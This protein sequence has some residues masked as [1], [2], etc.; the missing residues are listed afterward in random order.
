MSAKLLKYELSHSYSSII[1]EPRF[2]AWPVNVY[3]MALPIQKKM[4]S[5]LNCFETFVLK[6]LRAVKWTTL[7]AFA[8]ET[9]LD[10]STLSEI[11]RKLKD[12]EYIDD[13]HNVVF[14]KMEELDSVE[15]DYKTAFIFQDAISGSFLPY[16]QYG[17]LV[18]DTET[19]EDEYLEIQRTQNQNP[20][21]TPQTDDVWRA[22]RRM[23]KK[24]AFYDQ[25][26]PISVRAE[27]KIKIMPKSEQ[28]HLLCPIV[29]PKGGL[30]DFRIY[31][32]FGVG[33]ESDLENSFKL[34]LAKDESFVQ[35]WFARWKQTLKAKESSATTKKKFAFDACKDRYPELV[36]QLRPDVG[37]QFRSAS[38]IYASIEWALYYYAQKFDWNSAIDNLENLVF[39]K[40]LEQKLEFILSRFGI[41]PV[42]LITSLY[43]ERV[44]K[45]KSGIVEMGAIW[46][47]AL[48]QLDSNRGNAEN[49]LTLL[50]EHPDIFMR[51][52]KL[53]S[54]RGADR[55]GRNEGAIADVEL[56]DDKLMREI[57][58][59][60]LPDVDFE[61]AQQTVSASIDAEDAIFNARIS[62]QQ[63][64][65][66]ISVFNK[67]RPAL[68]RYLIDAERID[69][70]ISLQHSDE[71]DC[72]GFIGALY[73]A[74][75][76]V[77]DEKLEDSI[78]SEGNKESA[79][80]NAV[81]AGFATI[82]DAILSVKRD[83]VALGTTLGA[84]VL[85]YLATADIEDLKVC[86][87]N[88]PEM[89]D[90]ISEVIV[91]S[92]HGNAKLTM[93]P[94]KREELKQKVYIL[95]KELLR[96]D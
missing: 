51:I 33:F 88:N 9:C 10:V 4:S 13:N 16:I 93:S 31:S 32:P 81:Q 49:M 29:V 42:R 35:S 72:S 54:Y 53:S 70:N 74:L 76:S 36:N 60:L 91:L 22:I 79:K 58:H 67:M 26:C 89:L 83:R 24:Y 92:G 44:Q 39:R 43:K 38:K 3:R 46:A 41:M 12:K 21:S 45:L 1:G 48:L 59:T 40:E 20:L 87:Q 84:C 17:H 78:T 80:A 94:Q 6:M 30:D 66:G 11:L 75:Q 73:S 5:S 25:P 63:D 56:A 15:Y 82:P 18:N 86:A 57:V 2:I 68:Q 62:L 27:S 47:V 90:T 37:R 34:L 8:E 71:E 96:N 7:E 23:K 19:E 14:G 50:R 77:M 61:N 95:I 69:K 85:N 64:Y 52:E 55:H 28:R 65:F